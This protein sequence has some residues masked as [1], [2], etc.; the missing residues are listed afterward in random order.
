MNKWQLTFCMLACVFNDEIITINI[1]T[2]K[3][4]CVGYP[5]TIIFGCW[6]FLTYTLPESSRQ[7]IW[8]FTFFYVY[9]RKMAKSCI[10]MSYDVATFVSGTIH[11][12]LTC[13]ILNYTMTSV[14]RKF[15]P[16]CP[17]SSYLST[18]LMS[19]PVNHSKPHQ[20][21][22]LP[23]FQILFPKINQLSNNLKY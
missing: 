21:P 5:A 15:L 11:L 10:Q 14:L 23:L 16:Q 2:H 22:F 4:V 6:Q 1:I 19:L 7:V 8:L 13:I 3:I 9:F 18:H 20:P 12:R 17:P